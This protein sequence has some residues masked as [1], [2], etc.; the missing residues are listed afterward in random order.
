[1]ENKGAL[2]HLFGTE[3]KRSLT[4]KFFLVPVG[5]VLCICLDTW[6]QIPFMWTSPETMDVY[7]YWC[8]SFIF[9]GFYGIYVIP[10]LAALPYA[11]SFCEEYNTNMLKVLLIKAGK[12]KYC[13]SKVLM[14]FLSGAL[15]VSA[16]GIAF[17]ILANSFVQLF[18]RARLPETE[19]FPFYE[20]LL[21]GNVTGYFTAVIFLL[22]LTGGLWAT[23]ALLVS[24]YFPNI[25]VTVA[26]PLILSFL[27]SRAYLVLKIPAGLRF[28]LWLQGRSSAGTDW[29]TLLYSV[30]VVLVLTVGF[31]VLFYRKLKRR[32]E[33]E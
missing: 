24:L 3:F 4:V 8:N 21:Q 16:G 15:S 12:K 13:I 10:M 26:S 17:I 30:V 7:Y 27:T 14:T 31:G 25:Y 28:D 20:L 1:M 29:L 11:V 6:N 9:G 23:V 22:F 33:N 32:V 18:N 5:V 2:S 19:A